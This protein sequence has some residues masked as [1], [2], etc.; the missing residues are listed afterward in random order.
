[1]S[2]GSHD[3]SPFRRFSASEWESLRK[4]V[5]LDLNEEELSQLRGLGETVDLREVEQIYLP[6]SRLLNLYVEGKQSLFGATNAFLGSEQKVPFIIGIGGSVAVGKSTTSRILRHLLARWPNHP[7][8]D[9]VTT[10]GFLY[11]NATLLEHNLMDRKGFPESFNT[12][13]LRAFL[14]DVKSGRKTVDAP[15]YSHL[16]YDILPNETVSVSQPD[17]LIVEG[18]NVLQP[19]RLQED[20]DDIP[21][22]SDYF[23]FSIF[24]DADRDDVQQWYID[25]FLSLKDTAFRKPG[26]YF[27]RY[28]DLTKEQAIETA[29]DIWTRINLKNLIENIQPTRGRADLIL[30]KAKNHSI[31]QVLLRKI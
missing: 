28:A 26:A 10:D 3:L 8:V 11:P 5:S 13:L 31:D 20:S 25:R 24:I 22:V 30:H 2:I 21:F 4:G 14:N 12:D 27:Q 17:I 15:I 9:L 6:L 7:K 19:A 1:M 23:D 29:T 18:L 16:A